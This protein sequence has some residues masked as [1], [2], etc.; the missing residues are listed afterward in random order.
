MERNKDLV[1]FPMTHFG[2]T[3]IAVTRCPTPY[4]EVI[5]CDSMLFNGI[6]IVIKLSINKCVIL[7]MPPN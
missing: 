7:R 6:G 5:Q 4:F 2:C 3:K 1:H